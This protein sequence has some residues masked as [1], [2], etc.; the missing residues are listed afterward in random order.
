MNECVYHRIKPKNYYR[1]AIWKGIQSGA[2]KY[3]DNMDHFISPCSSNPITSTKQIAVF[4]EDEIRAYFR[5]QEVKKQRK[6]P[7]Q[8]VVG[9]ICHAE[10]D[11]KY[12][13]PSQ[14]DDTIQVWIHMTDL[15][16]AVGRLSFV[17]RMM[18]TRNVFIEIQA[19][20]FEWKSESLGAEIM[21][22]LRT[23]SNAEDFEV[24]EVFSY[25]LK[26][27]WYE[28]RV[29]VTGNKL[30][31]AYSAPF[32]LFSEKQDMDDNRIK[33]WQRLEFL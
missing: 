19:S 11:L 24:K 32:T 3:E 33:E 6:K 8:I 9:L 16:D 1:Y 30:A 14:Y 17:H 12:P 13:L 28:S 10:D 29:N 21:R 27:S 5:F 22:R 31:Q 18:V 7:Y 23:L 15:K 20:Q 4:N 25:G 2:I 26:G